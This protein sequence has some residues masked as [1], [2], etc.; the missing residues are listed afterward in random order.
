MN[1]KTIASDLTNNEIQNNIRYIE[2]NKNI[3]K[4]SDKPDEPDESTT[5]EP[6]IYRR[7]LGKIDWDATDVYGRITIYDIDVRVT[8]IKYTRWW[9]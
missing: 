9:N 2:V 7:V 3:A 5:H 8:N 6:M 1:I 4:L